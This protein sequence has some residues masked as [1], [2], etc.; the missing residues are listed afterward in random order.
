MS[1]VWRINL[2]SGEMADVQWP[3]KWVLLPILI[4]QMLDWVED[5]SKNPD[6]R[7]DPRCKV[8]H[9]VVKRMD[10]LLTQLENEEMDEESLSA[11]LRTVN[12]NIFTRI[13]LHTWPVSQSVSVRNAS[14]DGILRKTYTATLL[15]E[16]PPE[17]R[18]STTNPNLFY[19]ENLYPL[20]RIDKSPKWSRFWGADDAGLFWFIVEWLPESE[21]WFT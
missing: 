21:W 16:I 10:N 18:R 13:L 2:I 9:R 20:L 8:S 5:V 19:M 11:W 6:I 3:L 14:Q 12:H 4:G 7:R 1:K 17:E 15:I